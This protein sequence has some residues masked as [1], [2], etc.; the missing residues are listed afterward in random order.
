MSEYEYIEHP[1]KKKVYTSL[2]ACNRQLTAK[3]G[4]PTIIDRMIKFLGKKPDIYFGITDGIK[5]TE[6]ITVDIN[7]KNNPTVVANWD[8]LPFNDNQFDFAFWDPP[9][10]KR[11][12]RGLE[13]ILRVTKRRVAILHQL[14]YPNPE[15]WI[16]FAI[17]GV[18]TG[19]NMRIR[20]LQ[21]YDRSLQTKLVDY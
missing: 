1:V 15:G 3:W 7:P 21:I 6:A 20:V 5:D 10:D 17:I 19:P 4:C 12:V 13:E 16:K 8:K 11:Y 18:T 14:V 2:W 9:Y